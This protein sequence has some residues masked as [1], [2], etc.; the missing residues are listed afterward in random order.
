MAPARQVALPQAVGETDPSFAPDVIAGLTGRP[1]RIPAKYFYDA[2]GAQLFEAITR[3]PE[4]YLTRCELSIL[5]ERGREIAALLPEGSA[6]IELG[7]GSSEKARIL[8]SVA[9]GIRLY[10]PVDISR[11]ML[12]EEAERLQRDYPGLCVIPVQADFA[13]PFV[14]PAPVLRVTRSGF[15]PG[16]TVGNFEPPAAVEFF[17]R[18][19]RTL[20]HRAALIVGVDLIKSAQVLDAAYNDAAG[21][22]R[23]FNLNL[24]SRMNR[25]L[26]ADFDLA[27]FEHRAFFNSG[28]DRVEMHLASRKAQR[29]RVAGRVIEF[30][31]DETIHTEN[32]YKYSIASFADLARRAGWE[33]ASSWADAGSM[34]SVHALRNAA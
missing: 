21:F 6:L 7:S 22:T 27:S 12:S 16:S 14:L 31:K 33:P 5:R 25:E 10:A 3:T 4:Y 9:P 11:E 29:I 18:L 2:R 20:G 15:F 26:N 30:K 13:E 1:K 23:E 28:R 34:F 19:G 8:L 17:R 32:S 24:L